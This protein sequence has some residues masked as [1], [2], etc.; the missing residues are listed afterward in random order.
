MCPLNNQL[1]NGSGAGLRSLQ[2]QP[3]MIKTALLDGYDWWLF[4]ME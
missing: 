1:L 4:E 2:S 3:S